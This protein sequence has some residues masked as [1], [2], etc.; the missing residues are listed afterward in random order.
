[1]LVLI[2]EDE[3]LIGLALELAVREAGHQILGPIDNVEG[4]LTMVDHSVPSL[5]LIDIDLRDGGNGTVLARAL[6]DRYQV[7]VLFLSAQVTQARMHRNVAW[8]LI[9]KPYEISDVLRSVAFVDNVMAKRPASVPP[10][11][12]LWRTPDQ[13]KG[14]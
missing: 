7:P 10:R 11:L 3:V 4:A 2:V 5:A 9:T 14:G 1:M 8:G 6:H 13:A 12:E